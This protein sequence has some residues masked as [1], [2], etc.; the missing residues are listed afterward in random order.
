MLDDAQPTV[1]QRKAGAM[2][3]QFSSP[4]MSPGRAWHLSMPKVADKRLGLEAS[5]LSF[6]D[7]REVPEELLS[8]VPKSTLLLRLTDGLDRLG[9]ALLDAQL[10]AAL[11]EVQTIGLVNSSPPSKRRP[12]PT[13]AA[14]SAGIFDAWATAFDEEVSVMSRP[15]PWAGARAAGS[16]PDARSA[17]MILPPQELHVARI[18]LDL[19]GRARQGQLA[20]AM[21]PISASQS[22]SPGG[23]LSKKPFGTELRPIIYDSPAAL[24]AVLYRPRLPYEKVERF[25]PGDVVQIPVEALTQVALE[26]SDGKIVARAR[27]GQ[28]EG[29]R[30][31][32]LMLTENQD[33]PQGTV[34]FEMPSLGLDGSSMPDE[35]N[36]VVGDGADTAGLDVDGTDMDES[37]PGL[38]T[39]L[40]PIQAADIGQ[41]GT[42]PEIPDV[43]DN[44]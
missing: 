6:H 30:A 11:I 4:V 23:S 36:A 19:G 39:P 3:G 7:S 41:F 26:A 32:R 28:V 18:S 24:E 5:V 16:L 2:R 34:G 20:I 37:K 40:D 29:T 8:E 38:T 21:P 17:L 44:P 42:S 33:V 15:P 35:I 9:L 1:M 10:L 13:D 22:R 12:T 14:I 31:V 43:P 25:S 27:L